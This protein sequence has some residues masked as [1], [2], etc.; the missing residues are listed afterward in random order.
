MIPIHFVFYSDLGEDVEEAFRAVSMEEFEDAAFTVEH[1]TEFKK[2][3]GQLPVLITTYTSRLKKVE[4]H[5]FR[6]VFCADSS[7]ISGITFDVL[8]P[9]KE[10]I[11]ERVEHFR[12]LLRLLVA[13][14]RAWEYRMLLDATINT[15]QDM[16]WYKRT[17]GI[18]MLVNDSVA[19]TVHKDKRDIVGKDHYAIW[20]VSAP[21]SGEEAHDC[22][23]SERIPCP[24]A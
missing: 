7:Q 12:E 15:V 17:D 3:E 10:S 11:E 5:G 9:A 22:S 24:T 16:L 13:E 14:H 4:G 6:T 21:K 2:P 1:V 8:W 23:E 20:D 18:H 19:R